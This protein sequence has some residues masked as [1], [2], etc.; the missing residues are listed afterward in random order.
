MAGLFDEPRP[1]TRQITG[2][3]IEDVNV[4]RLRMLG[5]TSIPWNHAVDLPAGIARSAHR[6][7]ARH[8]AGLL[9]APLLVDTRRT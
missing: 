7:P 1:G 8:H 6:I 4:R 2:A 5:C 3:Q 9:R